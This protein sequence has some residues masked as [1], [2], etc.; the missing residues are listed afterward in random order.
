MTTLHLLSHSPFGDDRFD[1]C[2]RL[3]GSRDGVL[4]TGDATYA[5]CGDSL[6]ARGLAA[7]PKGFPLF[8]LDEDMHARG[9]SAP[10]HCTVIDYPGFVELCGRFDKVNGWL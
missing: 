9:L 4:L 10:G 7:L 1:S 2:L 5:L 3:L 8:A 6:P